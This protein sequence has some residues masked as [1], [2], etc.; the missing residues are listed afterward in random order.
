MASSAQ[1]P[2][3]RTRPA[4][5][6][7]IRTCGGDTIVFAPARPTLS[8]LGP[9]QQLPSPAED[10]HSD[11]PA[12]SLRRQDQLAEE[13]P[14][15]QINSRPLGVKGSGREKSSTIA[16]TK[17]KQKSRSKPRTISATLGSSSLKGVQEKAGRIRANL[18][19]LTQAFAESSDSFSYSV[20]SSSFRAAEGSRRQAS[21]ISAS[22]IP[23]RSV[24][25][26]CPC[27]NP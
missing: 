20:P 1:N 23:H 2:Q 14:R 16:T 9:T 22:A 19:N 10:E 18:L 21:T 26:Y 7:S 11:S 8:S 6:I 3:S 15:G 4:V 13:M 27:L 24:L 17:P 12:E 5:S 25:T